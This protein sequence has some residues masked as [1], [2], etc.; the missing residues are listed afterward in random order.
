[1]FTGIIRYIGNICAVSHAKGGTTISVIIKGD[2]MPDISPGDSIAVDGVC[3][4]AVSCDNKSF[5]VD[6]SK[7]TL[8][9]TTLQFANIGA[10][11]NIEPALRIGDKVGGHFVTGHVDGIGSIINFDRRNNEWMLETRTDDR[12][13]NFI[14]EKGSIAVDGISLTVANIRPT[15]FTSVIVPFTFT[16]TNLQTKKSGDRVNIETDIIGKYIMKQTGKREDLTEDFLKS[17]GF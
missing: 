8:Q 12:M 16:H 10:R 7:E 6:V 17:R 2:D 14:V 11:V 5:A 4:T 9:K 15:S 1:M 3:L 13:M